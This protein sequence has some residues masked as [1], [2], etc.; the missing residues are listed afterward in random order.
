M[1]N[2]F[3]YYIYNINIFSIIEGK[4]ITYIFSFKLKKT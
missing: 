2:I 4:I 3:I 1:K